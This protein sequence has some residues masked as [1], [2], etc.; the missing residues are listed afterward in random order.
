ML[1]FRTAHPCLLPRT[2][3]LCRNDNALPRRY[4]GRSVWSVWLLARR[5][6]NVAG[7]SAVVGP[8][9][10]RHTLPRANACGAPSG[11]APSTQIAPVLP[12]ALEVVGALQL[13]TQHTRVLA[14]AMA[15]RGRG[16]LPPAHRTARPHLRRH[17][18]LTSLAPRARRVV[19]GH[20]AQSHIC[21]S[22]VCRIDHAGVDDWWRGP[23]RHG[24][25]CQ[26]R[27]RQRTAL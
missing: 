18:C 4:R 21:P 1:A 11:G 2:G 20:V 17:G 5:V 27:A 19:D 8:G 14:S 25:R 3:S 6:A 12:T 24:C 15:G 22:I 10:T 9:Q 7:Q 16:M 26:W 23:E 13:A